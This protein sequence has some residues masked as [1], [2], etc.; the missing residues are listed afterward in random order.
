MYKY[1]WKRNCKGDRLQK[2][3]AVQMTQEGGQLQKLKKIEAASS[4]GGGSQVACSDI[5]KTSDDVTTADDDV[6][7]T[8]EAIATHDWSGDSD[9]EN[10]DEIEGSRSETHADSRE[11]RGK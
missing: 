4:G 3:N 6:R 5:I 10:K 8:A 7:R 9:V 11:K 2:E 1:F